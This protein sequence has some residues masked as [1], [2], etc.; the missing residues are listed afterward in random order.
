[1]GVPIFIRLENSFEKA[2]NYY[3]SPQMTEYSFEGVQLLPNNPLPYRQRTNASEGIEIEEWTVLVKSLC[4]K[5]LEDITD[6]FDVYNNFNDE[7]TGLPQ[8]DWQILNCPYDFNYQLVYLEINTGA[9]GYIYS[10][11]FYFTNA[12]YEWVSDFYYGNLD[13]F[14]E[15]YTPKLFGI[16]LRLYYR[17]PKSMLEVS[18]YTSISSG[19][20][21][22]VSAKKTPF[23]RWNTDWNEIQSFELL[24]DIFLCKYVYSR[25]FND[26][27]PVRTGLYEAFETPDLQMDE[28][29][30][31]QEINLLRDY[32]LSYDPN[33]IPPTPPPPPVDPPTINLISASNESK[34]YIT[35]TF[36]LI[37]FAPTYLIY[38]F[39]P[40]GIDWTG[41]T[42]APISPYQ[43]FIGNTNMSTY[44]F[45]I[46]HASGV[47]SNVVQMQQPEMVITNITSPQTEFIQI[48][49][50]YNI[51]YDVIGF[52]PTGN[53]GVQGR[54]GD[55]QP[56]QNLYYSTGNQN[57]KVVTTPSSGSEF[58]QFRVVY[59][60]LGL[61]SAPYNFEF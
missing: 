39:S 9:D 43:L 17:Q 51:F 50:N 14:G 52:T 19:K 4:G 11:P 25:T 58:T 44:Y 12:N 54:T 8:V 20:T 30:A 49:N 28:N 5:T 27:L 13:A 2:I 23:E 53:V 32:S 56:W 60:N 22:T 45:R 41:N 33:Y 16:G 40:D 59:Y 29:S 3:N 15:T 24:K 47:V 6:Y 21:F 1:M 34:G 57:P 55:G 31:E 61:T 35:Y 26:T 18:N 48:G 37:N 46:S 36:E 42:N 38:E 7:N 10:T